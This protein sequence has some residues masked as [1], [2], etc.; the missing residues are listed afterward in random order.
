[1]QILPSALVDL[2]YPNCCAGC[3]TPLFSHEH[4]ICTS[5]LESL[6]LTESL[7][8]PENE[9]EKIFWGRVPVLSAG[10]LLYFVKGGILQNILHQL[11]Y[12]GNEGAGEELGRISGE[13]LLKSE[14]FNAIDC[15]I[16]IPLHEKK[17]KKRG[18]NQCSFIAKKIAQT[19]GSEYNDY[20]LTKVTH[21]ESQTRKS[22]F[23]RW[24]NVKT[25]FQTQ[26]PEAISG[27]HVLLIDD[28]VT[29]GSTLEAAAQ[30]LLETEGVR[31]SIFT[32]AYTQ[33]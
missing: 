9:V 26:Q 28:V 25:V 1:M 23:Q 31:V 18:Y 15:V 16:P 21:N 32:V 5:C 3:N 2:F 11:K 12:K 17:M 30:K 24:L 20:S 19:L 27:K 22:K 13:A 8:D 6:P 14:R 29:T 4:S 33:K 7:N 10:A